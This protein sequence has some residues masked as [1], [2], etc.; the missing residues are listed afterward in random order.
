MYILEK[1]NMSSPQV[2]L[3]ALAGQAGRGEARTAR[4]QNVDQSNSVRGEHGNM[5]RRHDETASFEYIISLVYERSRIRLHDGKHSLIRARLGKRMRHHGF[6]HLSDYCSYLQSTGDEEEVTHVVD[7]LTTN[8]TSFLREKSHFEFLVRH[9][10]PE[11]LAPSQRSFQVWSAACATG[12]EP[13]SLACYLAEFYPPVSG[14]NWRILATDIS[15]KALRKAEAG[16]YPLDRIE[17]LPLEWRRRYFQ[18]GT[19]QW[20]GHC[21]VKPAL[22]ERVE[23]RQLNLL[24]PYTIPDPFPVILCRNVM[25]YFDRPTQ[26]QLVRQL[27]RFL[28]PKGYLLIGHSESLN[29]LSIGM[30]CL[31]PSVYQKT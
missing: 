8:F 15:T 29:G 16:V 23:F 31:R 22:A 21:R 10:L 1:T 7:A 27:S 19:G 24:E 28:V 11:L 13:F 30:R 20:E 26:E 9:A 18:R 2:L 6:E 4:V 12:E 14:W 5:S 25:I 3:G 17:G